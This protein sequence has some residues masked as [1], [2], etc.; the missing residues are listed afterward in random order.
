MHSCCFQSEKVPNYLQPVLKA[1]LVSPIPTLPCH[2]QWVPRF[3]FLS[4]S[5]NPHCISPGFLRIQCWKAPHIF[6]SWSHQ[7]PIS[8]LSQAF[9]GNLTGTGNRAYTSVL[10]ACSESSSG[11]FKLS[12]KFPESL[13]KMPKMLIHLLCPV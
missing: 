6:F 12:T 1:T 7:V 4:F 2:S 13:W 8:D 5:P 10:S 9:S 11:S 3:T